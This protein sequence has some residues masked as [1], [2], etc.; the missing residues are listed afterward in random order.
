MRRQVTRSSPR[1]I[2]AGDARVRRSRRVTARPQEV[3]RG[4]RRHDTRRHDVA[5]RHPPPPTSVA[6]SLASL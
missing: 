6:S 2:D 1:A 5:I 4:M 3:G